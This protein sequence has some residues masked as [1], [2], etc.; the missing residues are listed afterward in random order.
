[1]RTLE[2]DYEYKM[3]VAGGLRSAGFQPQRSIP[4]GIVKCDDVIFVTVYEWQTAGFGG[5]GF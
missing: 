3:L 4:D 2:I 5:T 1:M